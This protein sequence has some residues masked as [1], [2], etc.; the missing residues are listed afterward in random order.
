MCRFSLSTM[1]AMSLPRSTYPARLDTKPY[2][3]FEYWDNPEATA[4]S[5]EAG[6]FCTGDIGVVEDGYFRIM[7]VLR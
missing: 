3:I 6:W 7:G 1:L 2:G 5:F 4:A